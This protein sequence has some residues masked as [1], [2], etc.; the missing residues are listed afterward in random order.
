MLTKRDGPITTLMLNRPEKRNALS[1][2]LV[3]ALLVALD[4]AQSDGT[5]LLVLKGEGKGFSG[6]FDFGGIEYQ[7]D[8][9]LALRFIRLELLLQALYHSPHAT[10]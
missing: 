9:D 5:R 6:G 3:D 2:E 8:A 7:S 10:M 4:D 1:A